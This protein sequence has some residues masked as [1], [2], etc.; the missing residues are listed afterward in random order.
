MNYQGLLLL[1]KPEKMTSHDLVARVR[2]IL[3]MKSV[4]HCG[5]LDP[6]ATGLM[7]LLLGEATKLSQYLLEREKSY[8][9]SLK[10][11]QET[12]TGDI[13]GEV[14]STK[15]V[16]VTEAQIRGAAAQLVG[17]FEFAVPKYSAIKVDGE[18]LYEKARRD[19]EFTP[20]LKKMDFFNLK[21]LA[22]GPDGLEAEISC[23][24]GSY[25]RSWITEL[26]KLLGCGAVMTG[27]R[28]LESLPYHLSQAVTLDELEVTAKSTEGVQK[29]Y[30]PLAELLP[31]WRLIRAEGLSLSLLR[32]GQISTALKAQMIAIFKPEVDVG[33][34][35][36]A[37]EDGTLVALVGLEP[38]RG[39]V[40][41]RVF[42]P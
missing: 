33:I 22:V 32:N 6:M 9:L 3:N 38:G 31:D 13:T 19:E 23:S 1:D 4:G 20:P 14:T 15:P 5:T 2:R 17:S 10:L 16:Q 24:K 41:R 12:N 11:G 28:R 21:I 26:G 39:F 25:I 42:R 7:I 34:K 37:R 18:K 40:I 30:L 35:V 8:R 27:L 29:G 36:V